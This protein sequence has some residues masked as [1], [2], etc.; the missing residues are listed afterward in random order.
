[1]SELVGGDRVAIVERHLEQNSKNLE[2]R[3]EALLARAR[4]RLAQWEAGTL[5][6]KVQAQWLAKPR[7]HGGN[8]LPDR[9]EVPRV[10]G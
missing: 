1:M 4:Q 5:P 8:E 2:H 6:A 9:G 7:P 10:R 3:T